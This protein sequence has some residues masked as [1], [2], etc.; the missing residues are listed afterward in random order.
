MNKI[1]ILLLFLAFFSCKNKAVREVQ[2]TYVRS[3]TFIEELTEEGTLRAVQFP[4][5]RLTFPTGMGDLKLLL[6]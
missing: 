4:L 2:T 1:S 6:S 5:M 3:G